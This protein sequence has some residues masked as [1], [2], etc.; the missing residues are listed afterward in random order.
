MS[1]YLIKLK[2]IF[3]YL[4]VRTSSYMWTEESHNFPKIIG[5]KVVIVKIRWICR[6]IH[7][8]REAG[9]G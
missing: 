1:L 7:R 8:K 6:K 9:P 5:I 3:I 2:Y 4:Y